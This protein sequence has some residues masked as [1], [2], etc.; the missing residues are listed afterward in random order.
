MTPRAS[1][2]VSS[3]KSGFGHGRPAAT[4]S[5]EDSDTPDGFSTFAR[6]RE[7][8]GGRR[9]S[10]STDADQ[11]LVDELVGAV[12]A[13]LASEAGAF[14]AAERQLSSVRADDVHVDHAGVDPVGNAL[15]LL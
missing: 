5:V 11:L 8:S 3:A 6:F 9:S 13:E 1:G 15:G 7:P 2:S 4:E 10:C 14:R 12:A